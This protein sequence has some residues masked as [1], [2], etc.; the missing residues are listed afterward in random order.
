MPNEL[1]CITN[2]LLQRSESPFSISRFSHHDVFSNFP[3]SVI[4]HALSL[5]YLYWEFQ[6]AHMEMA[7]YTLSAKTFV[8]CFQIPIL[9]SIL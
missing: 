4:K 1:K 3:Y 6:L 2:L 8:L 9:H 5:L 7:N